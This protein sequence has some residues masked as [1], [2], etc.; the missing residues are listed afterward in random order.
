MQ[1]QLKKI[2]FA[3]FRN[4]LF[5]LLFFMFTRLL[6]LL[7]N[8]GYLRD[9]DLI[10]ILATFW[11]ALP[12]DI[13]TACYLMV[14]PVLIISVQSI[15]PSRWFDYILKGYT[16][17]CILI[18]C[19]IITAETAVYAEWK[20]K[21]HFKALLYLLHPA[22]IF[23]TAQ[24]WQVIVLSLMILIQLFVIFWVYNRFFYKKFRKEDR[25]IWVSICFF[26]LMPGLLFMGMRGGW[27]QIPINQS[28]SYFSKHSIL[29]LASV[30]SGWNLLYSVHK[31]VTLMSNNPFQFYDPAE[32]MKTL[33]NIYLVEKDSTLQ[34]LTTDRPN[35]VVFILEGWSADLIE[36]QGGE[37]GI[38]PFF[39]E[40]G[41]E[42]ILFTQ[43]FSSGTRSQQGMSAIFGGFPS[44]PLTTITEQ[45]EKCSKLPSLPR[46][47]GDNGYFTSFYFGGDLTYGNIIGYLMQSGFDK[48]Q[49][50]RDF[51]SS[52][53]RGKLGI[54]D[55]FTFPYFASELGKQRQPF[56]A[57]IFTTSTH[58][59]YD[60]NMREAHKW[61]EFEKKYV[62]AAYYSDDCFRKFFADAQKEDWYRNTL[63]IFISDH[64]HST[65]RNWDP[66]SADYNRIVFMMFGNVI[67]DNYIGMKIDKIGSQVDFAP[68]LLHQLNLSDTSFV[69]SKNLLNSFCPEFAYYSFEEGLGWVRPGA[70]FIYDARLDKNHLLEIDST[71]NISPEQM[72]IEGKSYLQC[73]FQQYL[74]Y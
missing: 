67:K 45:P 63:F 39:H 53:P 41:K 13:S 25:N 38:T 36:S 20:T 42:G 56:Y 2:F 16:F 62:N 32:A 6:Y 60:M 28:R 70:R 71:A 69:W 49:D 4:I 15:F 68:T 33:K 72:I 29:N 30:N 50:E 52:M 12:L 61:P 26:I 11:H 7:F 10:S 40:L 43:V 34:V 14:F 5:W 37:K 48:I 47:I 31:N 65:Y 54:H 64:G 1:L 21:L 46:I 19:L 23:R 44:H 57:N 18:F 8:I 74:D 59:P 17:I 27:Q 58:S 9:I 35:I 66:Y 3:I 24:T 55:E 73:V 22:E 51:P